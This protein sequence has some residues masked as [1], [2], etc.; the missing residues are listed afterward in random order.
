MK[1]T[2]FILPFLILSFTMMAQQIPL[3]EVEGNSEVSL[4]PDEALILISL[5][6]NAMTVA[7]ATNGLN[8]KT[9]AIEDALKKSG[10]KTYRLFVDNYYVNVNRVFTRGSSHDSGYVASQSIR[11]RVL[12]IEKDLIKVTE[13]I[14]QTGN[15]GFNL[16]LQVSDELKK[17][18]EEELL[19]KAIADAMRKAK[20]IAKSIGVQDIHVHKVNYTSSSQG[21]YPVMR[22]A[23]VAMAADMAPRDEPTFRP[24]ERKINDK[25]MVSFTFERK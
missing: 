7:D 4:M 23:R 9:K 19:E 3:I 2:M 22:E 15:P 20:V 12:D 5:N 10:V 16:S 17:A 14:Q 8:K 11:V 25:V 24:E 18:V 21:F 1:I 6:E 13:T